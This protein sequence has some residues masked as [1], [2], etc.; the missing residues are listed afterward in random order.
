MSLPLQI[1]EDALSLVNPVEIRNID[2]S[3][4]GSNP[5]TMMKGLIG[6]IDPAAYLQASS[7]NPPK[8]KHGKDVVLT[9]MPGGCAGFLESCK[10]PQPSRLWKSYQFILA[11]Y[12]F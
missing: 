6:D 3:S 5:K 12:F 8:K 9:R 10:S 2:L 11:I 7:E 1:L 4:S